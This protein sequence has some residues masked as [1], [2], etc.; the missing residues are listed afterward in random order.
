[1]YREKKLWYKII[2][3][4]I[5][6]HTFTYMYWDTMICERLGLQAKLFLPFPNKLVTAWSLLLK[7]WWN[8][9]HKYVNLQSL[10]AACQTWTPKPVP[11]VQTLQSYHHRPSWEYNLAYNLRGKGLIM[12]ILQLEAGE[13]I[14]LTCGAERNHTCLAE[15]IRKWS[16]VIPFVGNRPCRGNSDWQNQ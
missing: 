15:G 6:D 2:H 12:C 5:I 11:S 13:A 14:R 7:H 16:R 4:A 8:F 10:Q 9:L 3:N 1:M